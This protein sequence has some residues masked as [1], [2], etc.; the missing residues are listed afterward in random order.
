MKKKLNNGGIYI[1]TPNFGF[2]E[3]KF[4]KAIK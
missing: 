4:K 1:P 3:K 2:M